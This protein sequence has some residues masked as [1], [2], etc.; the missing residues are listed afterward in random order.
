VRVHLRGDTR[1]YDWKDIST[2]DP[3]SLIT[4]NLAS[5]TGSTTLTTDN[6]FPMKPLLSEAAQKA[7]LIY[8]STGVSYLN[9]QA[10][11]YGGGLNLSSL[12]DER[13]S[14]QDPAA[15][16]MEISFLK[17]SLED[18]YVPEDKVLKILCRCVN[19]A[20]GFHPFRFL[21]NAAPGDGV[22]A[23]FGENPSFASL[24]AS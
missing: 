13:S 7:G 1:F 10:A 21:L 5:L 6:F 11:F 12:L 20:M 9:T 16:E 3:S 19:L 18:H 23:Y 22:P 2:V 4:N 17:A 8:V 24:L 14:P 15:P